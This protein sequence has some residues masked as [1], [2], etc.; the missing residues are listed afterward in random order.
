MLC[1]RLLL[2]AAFVLALVVLWHPLSISASPDVTD[3]ARRFVKDHEAGETFGQEIDA[4]GGE[5]YALDRSGHS[6]EKAD[7]NS[8]GTDDS[9]TTTPGNNGGGDDNGGGY[10]YP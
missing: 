10:T 6:I 5:W 2:P 4:F 8:G 1:L 9:T 7:D 3:R